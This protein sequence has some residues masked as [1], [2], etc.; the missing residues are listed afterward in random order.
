MKFIGFAYR[1]ARYVTDR[2]N[3]AGFTYN[4]PITYLYLFTVYSIM[5]KNNNSEYHQQEMGLMS[6]KTCTRSKETFLTTVFCV[7]IYFLFKIES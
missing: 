7:K 4:S 2:Q 5:E 1:I 6:T 3:Y